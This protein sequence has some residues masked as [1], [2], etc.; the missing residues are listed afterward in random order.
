MSRKEL[1]TP[2]RKHNWL[3][4]ILQRSPPRNQ[5]LPPANCLSAYS[6]LQEWTVPQQWFLHFYALATLWTPAV[7]LLFWVSHAWDLAHEERWPCFAALALFELHVLRRF[8]ETLLVMRYP[9]GARMHGIAYLFS[10][11]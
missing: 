10:L 7:G 2:R 5:L 1:Y 6:C 3:M 9:P 11:T 4:S 8:L